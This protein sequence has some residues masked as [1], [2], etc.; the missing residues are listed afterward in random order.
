MVLGC[1][2]AHSKGDLHVCEDTIDTEVYIGI[3]ERRLSPSE[4]WL[5]PGSPWLFQQDIARPHSAHATTAWLR[6]HRVRVFDLP[7]CS[8]DL[9]PI[10]NVWCFMKRRI[11]QLQPRTV[12][13]LLSGLFVSSKN[14]QKFLR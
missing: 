3:L 8:S 6:R 1:I 4:Q 11:R 13:Q 2:S 14:G 9:S 12:E 7:V 5:I 10:A